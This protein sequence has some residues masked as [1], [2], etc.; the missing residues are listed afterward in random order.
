MA[1]EIKAVAFD[2]DGL[3]FNTETIYD[4]VGR[5]LLER[6]GKHVT[7]ELLLAMMGRPSRAALQILIDWHQLSDSIEQLEQEVEALFAELLEDNL[8]PMPGVQPLLEALDRSTVPKAI[9]TSSRRVLVDRMLRLS[10]MA[11]R[12]EFELTCEDV[13]EGKPHP[14]IYLLA[15]N[16]F[17]VA[18]A[19]MLV[20]EDSTIGC[21]A[22]VAAGAR[23]V[24]VPSKHPEMQDYGGAALVVETLH[25][26]RVYQMLGIDQSA[27]FTGS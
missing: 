1:C 25:D 3:L 9:T 8:A 7:R 2:L 5:I 12:F 17:G 4:E 14:E 26:R 24:A 15:A 19:E 16:R 18:P 10:N 23:V 20:L 21:R 11:R 22:A 27:R 6:R 13:K